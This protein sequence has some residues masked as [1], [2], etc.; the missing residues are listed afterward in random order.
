MTAQPD[1]LEQAG[2]VAEPKIVLNTPHAYAL[3]RKRYEGNEWVLLEEVAPATGGGTRYADAL[4][5]NLWNSR[6]HAIIGFE[7]KTSRSDWLRELK[8]PQKAEPIFRYCD[9]WNIVAPKGVV[10]DGE[11]PP[12]WGLMEVRAASLV[13]TVPAARLEPVP[14]TK[15]FFASLVRRAFEQVD[16]RAQNLVSAQLTEARQRNEEVIAQRVKERTRDIERLLEGVK[17]FKEKT[18][19]D[20]DPWVGPP[21]AVIKLAQQLEGLNGYDGKA[22]GRL[23][24]VANDLDRTAKSIREA[25]GETGLRPDAAEAQQ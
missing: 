2:E 21:I 8:Q 10:K 12:N 20:M 23:L 1:L 9:H 15:A 22:F 17:R 19:L 3:L 11:L 6:G 18:G 4:A 13:Q 16:R 25:V 14:I 24:T 5:I 7:V